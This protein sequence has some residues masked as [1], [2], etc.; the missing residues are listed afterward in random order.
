MHVEAC[1]CLSPGF[2]AYVAPRP[3][4]AAGVCILQCIHVINHSEIWITFDAPAF[5][6]R[7]VIVLNADSAM[8]LDFPSV[9]L[10][11]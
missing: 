2:G 6:S 1:A 8:P 3:G 7:L 10:L 9:G 4:S 11:D 5:L